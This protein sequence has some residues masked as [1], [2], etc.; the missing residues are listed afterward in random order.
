LVGGAIVKEN[1]VAGFPAGEGQARH[2]RVAAGERLD[3]TASFVGEPADPAA[4][5]GDGRRGSEN[6][7]RA[8]DRGGLGGGVL[9]W[10]GAADGWGGVDGDAVE[11]PGSV[12]RVGIDGF[13]QEAAGRGSELT[14]NGEAVEWPIGGSNLP[15]DFADRG[16]GGHAAADPIERR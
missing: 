8:K 12:A 14:G 1:S 9:R 7:W 11:A 3:E 2:F 4:E 10:L 15:R 6:G 16:A 5:E 13:E